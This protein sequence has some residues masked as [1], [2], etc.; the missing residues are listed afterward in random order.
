MDAHDEEAVGA[1]AERAG[2]APQHASSS[3]SSGPNV[4][5][6]TLGASSSARRPPALAFGVG[7][8]AFGGTKVLHTHAIITCK[9]QYYYYFNL[10]IGAHELVQLALSISKSQ[11][12]RK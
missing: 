8:L 2:S 6:R 10:R 9:V 4:A 1:E 7:A 12:D 3:V 11:D 5:E